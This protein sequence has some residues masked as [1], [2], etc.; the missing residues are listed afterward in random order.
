MHVAIIMHGNGQ[1][2]MQRGLPATASCAAGVAALRTTVALAAY[3]R[4]R[5]LT[6]YAV[7]SPG[8]ARPRQEVDADLCVLQRFLHDNLQ[9]C[10][11][12]SVR[13]SLIGN[14]EAPRPLLPTLGDHNEHLNVAGTRLH[15]RIVVDYSAHDSLTRAAWRSAD[16][17]APAQFI[18]QLRAIDPTAL[19]AGA[20]DLLVRTGAGWCRSDFMLWEV[21]YAKLYFVDRL[22]PDFTAHDF[23]Q[24]LSFHTRQN[25]LIS[26]D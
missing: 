1:L 21:A 8:G 13:I 4:V 10:A 17:H 6:L 26:A 23:Q 3:V 15:L 14:R 20:V 18:R 2:A 22:W 9:S 12:D 7:C 16:P 5:T 25:E 24:A 11:E 19:T